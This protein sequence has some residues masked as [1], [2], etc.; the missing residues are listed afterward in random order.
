MPI[1][2]LDRS[3]PPMFKQGPSAL[4]Q[5][6]FFAALCIFLMVADS[7]FR[8]VEPIRAVIATV[9]VPVQRALATPV[10]AWTT[11]SDYIAGV[12]VA[13][14]REEAALTRLAQQS[15][16]A[17]R[18]DRI[19]EE[20]ERLR[21]L[22]E[23]RPRLQVKSIAAEILYEAPDPFSRKVIIDRGLTHG[24]ERGSPVVNELGVLGQVSRAYPLTSEVTLLTDRDAAIPVLNS[25]TQQ[26]GAAFGDPLSVAA[27]S[28]MELRFMASNADVQVGD[29]L[30]TSGVDGVYPPGLAVAKV[31]QVDRRADSSF[32]KVL[33]TPVAV[34]DA[35]RLALVLQPVGRDLPP[36]P[37]PEV[38]VRPIGRGGGRR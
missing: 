1:G 19:A 2:T 12:T 3:P 9:V 30:T 28:G 32:A 35:I 33:L 37:A 24:V 23:L 22:L 10:Q 14:S 5:V 18:A 25:R 17:M 26:R 29:L 36:R 38:P 6:M 20:N 4:S 8:L 7:R 27:G 11:A 34:T 31:A 15:E 21:A 16:R 13:R